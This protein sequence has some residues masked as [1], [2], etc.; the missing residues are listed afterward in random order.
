MVVDRKWI[1]TS[2]RRCSSCGLL[3]RTPTTSAEESAR[4]YQAEYQEGFTTHLPSEDE[5][6][7]LLSGGFKN[8]EKDYRAY[9]DVLVA[10]GGVPGDRVVDF[11]CS[12]GY[13]SWQLKAKGFVVQGVEV[14]RDRCRFARTRLNIDAYESMVQL[15]SGFDYF[16][17]AHVIEHVPSVAKF[18]ETARELLR[19]GGIAVIFTPNACAIRRARAHTSFHKLW[20]LVHPQLID[21]VFVAKAFRTNS[22]LLATSP[23]DMD[24]LK[25]WHDSGGF[26]QSDLGGEELLLVFRKDA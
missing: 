7:R 16:F 9:I 1:V 2:L 5:L 6:T 11:G 21:E 17:S 4:F 19:P 14:S 25:A 26:S 12:W 22:A 18:I 8:T 23:Y 20:G 3:F 24:V 13:G 10:L 15:K